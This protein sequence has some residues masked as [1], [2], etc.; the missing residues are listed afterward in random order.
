MALCFVGTLL[1]R[2][3]RV[4]PAG[5][6]PELRRPLWGGI[7]TCTEIV[8]GVLKTSIS[9]FDVKAEGPGAAP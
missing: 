7:K 6:G 2:Q 1:S 4:E 3:G 9:A 5:I 8:G